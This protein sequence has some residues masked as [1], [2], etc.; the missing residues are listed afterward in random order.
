MSTLLVLGYETEEK[1]DEV[2]NKIMEMGKDY[3]ADIQSI[4]VVARQPDGKFKTVTPGSVVGESSMW[5]MFWGLLF[6]MLFFVPFLGAAMG[7]GLGAVFGG[8][9]KHGIDKEFQDRV[10]TLLTEKDAAAVFMVLNETTEDK[11]I[12]GLAPFGGDVL[13]TSLSIDDEKALEKALGGKGPGE[14]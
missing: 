4:A 1:A 8:M 7:A 13:Q 2:Y 12:N 3:I 10:K 5:G 11:F 9:A 14:E 6:G